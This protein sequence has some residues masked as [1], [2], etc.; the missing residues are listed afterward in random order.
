M[1]IFCTI[2]MLLCVMFTIKSEEKDSLL[3]I[4]VTRADSFYQAGDF[5][6]SILDC[7]RI[8]F[9]TNDFSIKTKTLFLKANCYKQMAS[10]NDAALTLMSVRTLGLSAES[11]YDL[12]YE[13]ALNNYFAGNADEA[14][15]YL[16]QLQD[17]DSARS[18]AG[19]TF[20]L[21]ILVMNTLGRWDSAKALVQQS[22]FFTENQK[23]D[24]L[25]IYAQNKRPFNAK[26]LD[27]YSRFVPGSGQLITGHWVEGGL[28]F[29]VC[30]SALSFGIFEVYNGYYLTGY[31]LGAGFLNGF[32]YGGLRRLSILVEYENKKRITSL[33]SQIKEYVEKNKAG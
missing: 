22:S 4:Y 26:R 5:S 14:L 29:F 13:L 23:K 15:T 3:N 24:L 27:W 33:N 28:S 16:E 21:N 6:K 7:E 8:L 31:F 30:A 9:L 17:I 25:L 2:C 10:F 18:F 19:N 12:F 32:Y 11:K 1:K 20:L